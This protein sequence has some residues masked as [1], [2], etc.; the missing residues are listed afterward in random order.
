MR[1]TAADVVHY[2]AQQPEEW[3]PPLNK[4]RL[5]CRNQLRGYR[6]GMTYGMPSY[7]RSGRVEVGFGKQT[8][9]LSLYILKQPVFEAHR[10]QLS[11]LRG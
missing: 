5:A 3:Q 11:G 1:S 4:L 8:R 10:A 9:Y 7:E 6:E 2:I